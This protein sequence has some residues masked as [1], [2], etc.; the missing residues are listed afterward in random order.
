MLYT[1]A[2]SSRL[3]LRWKGTDNALPAANES[4]QLKA[5]GYSNGHRDLG[6]LDKMPVHQAL[7]HLRPIRADR[8]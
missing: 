3:H 4:M 6:G 1:S 5:G 8:S 2:T 7:A